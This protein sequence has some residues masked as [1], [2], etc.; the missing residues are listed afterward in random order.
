[1]TKSILQPGVEIQTLYSEKFKSEL[2]L[3][4]KLPFEYNN[5]KTKVIPSHIS[6]MET[7]VSHFFLYIILILRDAH[8]GHKNNTIIVGIGYVVSDD[9]IKGLAEFFAWRSRDLNPNSK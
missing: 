9:R 4:I 3:F 5:E 8:V 2:L 1:M 6:W 7:I